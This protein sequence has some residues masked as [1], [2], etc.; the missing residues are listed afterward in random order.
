MI[1]IGADVAIR[2]GASLDGAKTVGARRQ[3]EVKGL[4]GMRRNLA[5]KL[6][7][8]RGALAEQAHLP[9]REG[10]NPGRGMESQ[11]D[12]AAEI[13]LVVDVARGAMRAFGQVLQP[14]HAGFRAA[15]ARAEQLP[16]HR[17]DALPR[18]RQEHLH[19]VVWRDRP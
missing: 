10:T 13:A 8:P 9:V 5:L 19:S 18:R 6:D 1:P 16:S 17:H 7:V 2:F 4:G 12:V 15:A 11:L 3:R 14:A